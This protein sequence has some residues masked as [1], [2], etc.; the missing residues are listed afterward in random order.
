MTKQLLELVQSLEV[1]SN[2]RSQIKILQ[3]VGD[4][5]ISSFCIQ[6]Q[7]L[8]RI[9]PLWVEAY[10]YHPEKF[11]DTSCH[12]SEMQKN[13]YGKLYFHKRGYGGIDLCLS[14]GD[15]CL[16]WLIKYSFFGDTFCSQIVL[17]RRLECVYGLDE[18]VLI[19]LPSNER[20]TGTIYHS[21]RVG[22]TC[23]NFK[24]AHLASLTGVEKYPFRFAKGY[25]RRRLEAKDNQH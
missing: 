17:R 21:P 23:G 13:R 20:Q 25:G 4:L 8:P 18:P 15:Y 5:L 19:Q 14:R 22:I 12:Q 10:Y 9:L 6:I 1:E 11:M 3:S 7:G 2:Q 16:S 24:S